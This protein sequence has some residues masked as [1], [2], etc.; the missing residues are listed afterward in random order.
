MTTGDEGARDLAAAADRIEARAW[1]DWF[2]A[3][4]PELRSELR[5]GVRHIADATLLIASRIPSTLFNRAI[6]LGMT[7]PATAEAIEEVV[8]AFADAG[9]PTFSVAWGPYSEPAALAQ[10]LES[11]LA[12]PSPRPRLAKMVRG[13]APPASGP[14]DLRVVAVD[15]SLVGDTDRAVAHAFDAPF[16]TGAV[17]ALLWRP[18]W[19]LYAA[20][21]GDAVAGGGALFLDGTDAWLGI[22][23]VLPEYRRRGGHRAL[24]VQRIRDAIAA[25][26]TRIF[27]EAAEP[28][29]KG[30]NPSLN[31]MER[32]GFEQILSRT[33]FTASVSSNG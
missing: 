25:G 12:A 14:T 17:T 23:A 6:G 2:A 10:R 8:K 16:L 7:R 31:N 29:E 3:S 11:L 32:C 28:P 26:A 9:S 22:G 20:M 13:T 4:P 5:M 15:R 24:M 1:A 27:T 21:D 19:H 18:G 30:A 33:D